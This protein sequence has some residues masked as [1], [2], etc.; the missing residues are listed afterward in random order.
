MNGLVGAWL[1]G[2]SLF[3]WRQVHVTHRLP[4]PG[5]LLGITGLFA[6]LGFAAAYQPA[7][8]LVTAVAWGLDIAAFFNAL[9]AGL[10]G[11]IAQAQTAESDSEYASAESV[12][13]RAAGA[14]A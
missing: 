11:Q 7:G 14:A 3:I 12:G 2:E 9:P 13:S 10:G 5:D 1:V 8:K 6:L 4:V